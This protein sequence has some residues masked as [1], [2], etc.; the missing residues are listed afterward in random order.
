M[1]STCLPSEPTETWL[2]ARWPRSQPGSLLTW[3]ST[4]AWEL[5]EPTAAF[6]DVA[7][8]HAPSPSPNPEGFSCIN[9]DLRQD[10][11]RALGLLS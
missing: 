3:W 8:G 2:G 7:L 10:S 9:V 4:L 6:I 1:A 11:D 5:V